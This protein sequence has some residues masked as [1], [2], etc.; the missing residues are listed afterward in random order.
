MRAVMKKSVLTASA[1][2]LLLA[3][4]FPTIMRRVDKTSLDFRG[5]AHVMTID[6]TLWF[7]RNGPFPLVPSGRS[8]PFPIVQTINGTPPA[9]QGSDEV[10]PG[11]HT[12]VV[13]VRWSN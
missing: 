3:G 6:D 12:F 1:C 9:R 8:P 10:I 11:A 2:A 5:K 4:C 7:R 13:A